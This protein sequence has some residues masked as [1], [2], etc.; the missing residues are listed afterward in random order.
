[1]LVTTSGPAVYN[2]ATAL[3][4]AYSDSVPVLLV[5]P[6]MPRQHPVGGPGHGYLHEAKDQ[7]GAMDR[8]A[9]R[10]VRPETHQEIADAVAGAFADFVGGRPRPVHVE[11]PL[12]LLEEPGDATVDV[13]LVANL[14]G[15]DQ[16]RVRQ[17][18]ELLVGAERPMVV[19]GG[20]AVDAADLVRRLAEQLGA[21][22]VTTI[23]GKGVL[24]EDHHLA[25]GARL[26]A[27]CV[28]DALEEADVL[29]VVGAELGNSDL[30]LRPLSPQGT[31]IRADVDERMKDVNV[32]AALYLGG[33]AQVTLQTLNRFVS[34]RI[35]DAS[36]PVPAVVTALRDRATRE[37]AVFGQRY[38]PWVAAV[39][40]ALDDD[41]VL[42]TDNAMSVYFGHVPNLQ[43]RRPASFHFPTG[44]GTLGFTVP[45]AIGAALAA[46]D[47][48]V[49]GLSGDGG[50]LFSATELAT[51]AAERLS[52]AVVVFDNQGYGEIRN[53][54][55]DRGEVPVA[56]AAPP[57][58]LVMLA[59]SLGAQSLSVDNPDQL[60]AALRAA[61]SHP[62]P[63][64]VVVPE[65]PREE[66]Q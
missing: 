30:W 33:F 11:V 63:T 12:D 9:E 29:L 5:S 39:Q 40:S 31:V 2:A 15:A 49:V 50:L 64:V 36:R 10:C 53:E 57:R 13:A 26:H 45:V 3:A 34:D 62:G 66:T 14:P 60:A 41:A 25:L 55:V 59:R 1:V 4:Q 17:A 19:A 44:F 7:T 51:A 32:E 38:L 21:P 24:P 8:I 48:Q 18:A 61:R 35:G 16:A 22:V 47:R 54:M 27:E 52:I 56:V 28:V 43:V 37:S 58:D 65:P 20:G 23:N 42:A 6:G 46:P